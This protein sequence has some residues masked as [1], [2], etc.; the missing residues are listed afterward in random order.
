MTTLLTFRDNIKAFATRISV[1]IRQTIFAITDCC[2]MCIFAIG[3]YCR[4]ICHFHR[5]AFV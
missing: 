1:R 3:D 4:N 5:I 2:C